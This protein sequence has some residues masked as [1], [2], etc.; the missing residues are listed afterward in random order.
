MRDRIDRRSF[1]AR[2]AAGVGIAAV[3]ASGGVLDAC[4]SGSGSGSSTA[5]DHPT[6]ITSATPSRGGQLVFGTEAEEKGFS[7]TQGTFDTTGILYARTVFDPLAIIA[8]DG[9]VQPYLAESI[10]PNADFT[11]WTITMR[12]NLTFHNGTPCDGAAV[13][14]NFALQQASGLTGAALTTI[15]DVSVPTHGWSP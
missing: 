13:A 5:A 8:A 10:T 12:P 11:V 4:G 1:L 14:E 6:G 2:G 15:A 3:G 9:S 7:T